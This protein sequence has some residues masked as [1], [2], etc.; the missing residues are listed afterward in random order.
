VHLAKT[1][2]RRENWTT[3]ATVTKNRVE[4]KRAGNRGYKP[5]SCTH[6]TLGNNFSISKNYTIMKISKEEEILIRNISICQSSMVHE[7]C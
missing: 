1:E 3:K 4:L 7:G 2:K 6:F 5:I